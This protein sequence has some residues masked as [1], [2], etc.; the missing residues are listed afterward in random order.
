MQNPRLAIRYA[1]SLLDLAKEQNKL[2]VVYEDMKLLDNLCKTNREFANVLKSPIIKEDKKNRIIESVTEGR[3]NLLTASFI[4][5]LGS[6]SREANL[7]EIISAFIEQYNVAKGIHRV[8]LT[9]AIE[10]SDEIK[11]DFIS[12]IKASEGVEHIE[13]ETLVDEDLVGGFVL[14]MEGYL[15]D[16]SIRRDL[17]DVQKQF[18]NNDYIQKLR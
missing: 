17:N 15:A 11:N 1:K 3:I 10:V 16:A 8:K 13:L 9:T 12:K 2:E 7:P 14:E 4:K 6:K 18:M 5:L